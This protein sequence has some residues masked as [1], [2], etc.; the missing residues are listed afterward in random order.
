[1]SIGMYAIGVLFALIVVSVGF[2]VVGQ[3]LV[4]NTQ[5]SSSA[6]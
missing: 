6:H 1:M 5:D 2:I 3:W 4:K